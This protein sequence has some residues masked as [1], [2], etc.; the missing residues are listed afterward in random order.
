MIMK[1]KMTFTHDGKEYAVLRP[2]PEQ[3]QAGRLVYNKA[4]NE[5]VQSKAFLR[6]ALNDILRQQGL[7]NDEKQK[8]YDTLVNEIRNENY[9]LEQGGIKLSEA[10][11][12]ALSIAQKRAEL[13]TLIV[14]QL[15]YDDHTAEAQAENKQFNYLLSLC[16]V[17]GETGTKRVFKDL[18]DYIQRADEPLS[19]EAATNFSSL[20][21]ELNSDYRL[22]LPENKFLIKYGFMDDKFRLIDKKTGNFVDRDGKRVNEDG[23]YVDENGNFIDVDGRPVDKD[24]KW[25]VDFQP[26][27]DDEGLVEAE[28]VTN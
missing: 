19:I 5:A 16:V 10:R 25:I 23:R 11:S 4:F 1:N 13:N 21:Y 22:G 12:L 6:S 7:W 27:V 14:K 2:T 15:E 8:R 28:P 26:F 18:D 24:G 9:K 17:D 3:E 20:K